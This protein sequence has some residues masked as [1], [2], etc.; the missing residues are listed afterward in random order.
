MEHNLLTS[1][2]DSILQSKTSEST[3]ILE[4]FDNGLQFF[5]RAEWKTCHEIVQSMKKNRLDVFLAL[6][7]YAQD[8]LLCQRLKNMMQSPLAEIVCIESACV[9][10]IDFM[11][12]ILQNTTQGQYFLQKTTDIATAFSGFL[13]HAFEQKHKLIFLMMNADEYSLAMVNHIYALKYMIYEK[14]PHKKYRTGCY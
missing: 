10:I 8:K 6:P 7:S 9:D 1:S 14:Y 3:D 4:M 5:S 13:I 12:I 2:L 11:K